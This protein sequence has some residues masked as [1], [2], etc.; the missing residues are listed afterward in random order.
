MGLLSRLR[1]TFLP[2]LRDRA[3]KVE[4][5]SEAMVLRVPIA[6]GQVAFHVPAPLLHDRAVRMLEKE[7]DTIEWLDRLGPDDVLWDVGANV[8]VF[9]LYAAV[10][11]RC[12]VVAFEP[13]AAN[14]HVLARNVQLNPGAR[15]DAYCVALAGATG[16]G[17]MNLASPA[18]G[19]AMAQFG[20]PGELSPYWH[21]P[22]GGIHGMVG[23]TVDEFIARFSPPFPTHMKLDVD[24]LEPAILRGA[25]A[26]LRDPRLRS[27]MAELP[28][29]DGAAHGE[30]LGALEAAGFAVGARGA[31][32]GEGR[33]RAAN[34]RFERR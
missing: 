32:Q 10:R 15:V 12:R 27:V 23:F 29:T 20:K 9:S 16:L 34:H 13:S 7:P 21:G 5:L 3:E 24:G 17:S 6:G 28:L 2:G 33:E 4:R 19:M 11:S 30:C 25:A 8:G 31:E 14:F 22:V 26:T 1:R 18:L